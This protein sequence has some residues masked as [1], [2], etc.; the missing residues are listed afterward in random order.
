METYPP[1]LIEAVVEGLVPSA[2]REHV[3]GDLSEQ[4]GSTGRYLLPALR[5]VPR[6]VAS[7]MRRNFDPAFLIIDACGLFM[8]FEAAWRLSDMPLIG[9]L[10]ELMR[11][12][13]PACA[14]LAGL[15]LRD[16]YVDPENRNAAQSVFDA[17]FAAAFAIAINVISAFVSPGM[18]LPATVITKAALIAVFIVSLVRMPFWAVVIRASEETVSAL[19]A[20]MQFQYRLRSTNPL[21]VV[22]RALATG[23][24]KW[25]ALV[26]VLMIFMTFQLPAPEAAGLE[27]RCMGL[28]ASTFGFALIAK[29]DRVV[30]RM[31]INASND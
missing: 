11:V 29:L 25:L 26:F 30:A 4:Y 1:R 18:S 27:L 7:R 9:S 3:A 23:V 19:E 14:A 5:I 24:W 13:L 20:A 12:M 8:A 6:I 31:V 2:C 10:S 16:A 17:V 15:A 21:L 22:C 28:A